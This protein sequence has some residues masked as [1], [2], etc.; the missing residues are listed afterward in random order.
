MTTRHSHILSAIAGILLLT[1]VPTYSA[2]APKSGANAIAPPPELSEIRRATL[3]PQSQYYY[4]KLMQMYQRNETVMT[5]LQYQYL[6]LGHMFRE[7]YNPYRLTTYPPHVQ[8][9]Y[10]SDKEL[11][12]AELDTVIKYAQ[13]ALDNNPFDLQQMNRL[14]YAYEKKGKVNIANIWKF[15]LRN[16]LQTIHSTGTGRD[17]EHAWTI[18]Y[19]LHAYAI[20]ASDK[21][22]IKSE[23]FDP[24]GY[25]VIETVAG[26]AKP[27]TYYFN[28]K[29]I[30]EEY[31]RKFPE[32]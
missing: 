31:Y 5:P 10:E 12:R 25:T 19:P 15:R 27:T 13:M 23:T 28:Y 1:A 32:E 2:R 18:T 9:I 3:D 22:S 24:E 30:L 8:A 16:I 11:R 14:I 7:D 20:F 17:K 6:Y 4:P 29:P 26:N 21:T